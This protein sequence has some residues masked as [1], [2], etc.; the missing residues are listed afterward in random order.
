MNLS[1][2]LPKPIP[3]HDT[4]SLPVQMSVILV[5]P[6]R[7]SHQCQSHILQDTSSLPSSPQTRIWS[8]LWSTN[9]LESV[10]RGSPLTITARSGSS[11]FWTGSRLRVSQ[12][13]HLENKKLKCVKLYVRTNAL[14]TAHGLICRKVKGGNMSVRARESARTT[15]TLAAKESGLT[16]S[17]HFSQKTSQPYCVLLNTY[18]LRILLSQKNKHLW[19]VV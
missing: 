11:S 16:V 2:F 15:T 4:Y 12:I 9:C 17:S 18:I 5:Y 14:T 1:V 6:P 3:N 13:E 19:Q 8:H 10:R 7:I